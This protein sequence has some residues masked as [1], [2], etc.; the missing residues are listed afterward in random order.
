MVKDQKKRSLLGRPSSFLTFFIFIVLI[1]IGSINLWGVLDSAYNWVMLVILVVASILF[2][3]HRWKH[4]AE[5]GG[6]HFDLGPY[7][8]LPRSW[9]RW[10]LGE[11]KDDRSQ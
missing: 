4:R 3:W 1:G 2:L 6:A 5:P 11:E 7:Y 10:L 8:L 9:R